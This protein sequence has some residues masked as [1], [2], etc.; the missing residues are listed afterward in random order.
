M[1]LSYEDTQRL[2]EFYKLCLDS[3]HQMLGYPVATDYDYQD[4]WSFFKFSINNVGDWA[5]ASNYPMN[6]FEFEQD[7]VD[8]F[9]RLFHTTTEQA[10]G[11]VTNGGTEGNMYGCYLARERFSDG[12]VYFS[13]DTHYSVMKIVRFLNVEHCIIDSQPNGE[14]DYDAL[15]SALRE[16]PHKPPIIFA[17]LGTTMLGAIDDLTQIQAR[18]HSVGFAREQYYLHADAAFHGMVVPYVDNPPPFSFEDGIDS[19]SVSGHK[20][21]G[22]PIP[23]GIVLALKA[24]TDRISH[25]IEYIDAPDKTLSGSRNGITP[26][27]LWAYIR[28]STKA[29]KQ[30]RIRDCLVLAQET[31][32]I[33]QAH[34]VEAWRN[35]NS[36]IVVFPKPCEVVWRKHHLAVANGV[37]HLVIAGQT[38]ACRQRLNQVIDDLIS[39]QTY[40]AI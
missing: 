24:H 18:L 23:C 21:L 5:Q 15:E 12:V 34:G 19:I 17:N 36:P 28:G 38:L 7:V 27:F 31:V 8:Y 40:L 4:L 11:Y 29:E 1:S 20:M 37:S 2:R 22:S 10:W 16:N 14:M 3:Q 30:Q 39:E 25:Q 33:L 13:K 26:L 9:C 6:T 35:P 32:E